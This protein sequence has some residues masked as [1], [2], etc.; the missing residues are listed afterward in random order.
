[1]TRSPVPVVCVD[2]SGSLRVGRV[3]FATQLVICAVLRY[4]VPR[5]AYRTM[6]QPLSDLLENRVLADEIDELGHLSV[7]YYESRALL[8]SRRLVQELGCDLEALAGRG[9]QFTLIDAYLRN[10]AEQFLDAPLLVRGGVLDAGS[11]R[12]SIYQELVNPERD[13]LAATFIYRFGLRSPDLS[14]RIAFD[15]RFTARAQTAA[16]ELPEHGAPRSL[17]IERSLKGL[18]LDEAMG[19]SLPSTRP[20]LID[21]QE[22]DDTGLFERGRFQSLPYIG[23]TPD[24][25]TMDWV[26]EADNGARLGIADLE[27]RNVL[28]TL[29]RAGDEVQT[30]SAN[31]V[32]GPK[33]FQRAHWVFNRSRDELISTAQT[34]A[35]PLD[36]EARKS[37]NMPPEMRARMEQQFH[38]QLL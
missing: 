25:Q 23:L 13:V 4:I 35:L 30:F 3:V 21:T 36:L 5:F 22:C 2:R 17:D 37:V 1:M 33:V 38:P 27:S 6:T 18:T 9:A 8:A 16:V 10:L 11:D 29:P 15:P 19:L 31:V 20:R 28:H 24:D 34:V 26:F 12:V 14:Q 32:M 7:P